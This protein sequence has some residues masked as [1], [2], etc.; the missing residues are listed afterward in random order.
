MK[1]LPALLSI[2]AFP[3]FAVTP[4]IDFSGK[5]LVMLV[6]VIVVAIIV[7]A[8]LNLLIDRLPTGVASEQSKA[9]GKYILLAVAVLI[10]VGW[11]LKW[12]GWW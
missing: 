6:V 12:I 5:S 4:D 3:V 9:W 2:V 10:V 11:L 8:L 7:F 1:Y